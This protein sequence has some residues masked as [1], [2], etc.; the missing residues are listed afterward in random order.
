MNTDFGC[1]F[2][3]EDLRAAILWSKAQ[4]PW[5]MTLEIVATH[6]LYGEVLEVFGPGGIVPRW[7]LHM[8]GDRIGLTG[9][10]GATEWFAALKDALLSIA[11]VPEGSDFAE[12]QVFP[13]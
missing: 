7:R 11:P 5:G 10:L 12:D 2:D 8:D 1:H 13:D 9:H 3:L 4:G 6:R